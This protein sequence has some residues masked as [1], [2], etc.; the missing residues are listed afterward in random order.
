MSTYLNCLI[1]HC[2]TFCV[3][4]KGICKRIYAHSFLFDIY[5]FFEVYLLSLHA[6]HSWGIFESYL[7]KIFAFCWSST[8]IVQIQ[9]TGSF[10]CFYH[11]SKAVWDDVKK[12][13]TINIAIIKTDWRKIVLRKTIIHHYFAS[14]W[15]I[16]LHHLTLS[17]G[18]AYILS[19]WM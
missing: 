4:F 1:S 18:C 15:Q 10:T 7:S 5:I 16:F 9:K 17:A 19:V 14:Y 12:M 13:V 2:M 8:T 11:G 3:A 6:Y